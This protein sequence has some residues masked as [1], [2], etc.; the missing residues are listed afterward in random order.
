MA[1]EEFKGDSVITEEVVREQLLEMVNSNSCWGDGPAK[2][3]KLQEIAPMPA[4]HYVMESFS[5][6]RVT[7]VNYLVY[8]RLY[9]V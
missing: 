6:S 4:L 1:M 2:D 9:F 7:Q 8:G 5:E 3:M